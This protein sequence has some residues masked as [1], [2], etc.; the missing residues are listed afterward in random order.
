MGKVH[1]VMDNDN[2]RRAVIFNVDNSSSSHTDNQRHGFLVLGEGDNFEINGRFCALE[3]K[4]SID[5]NKT[6][7]KFCVTIVIIV[8]CLLIHL[9]L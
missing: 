4:F 5:Y 1:G 7:T 8:I 3:K 9:N 2:F 6:K